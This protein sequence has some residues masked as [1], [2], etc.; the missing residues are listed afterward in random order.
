MKAITEEILRYELRNS[1]PEVYIIPKGKILTPAAREYLQQRKIRFEK[2]G[3]DTGRYQMKTP[4]KKEEAP[5]ADK[6]RVV[7]TEVPP[8]KKVEVPGQENGQP[9]PKYVD[10]ETGAFYYDKPEHMTQLSGNM[11][12]CKDHPRILFRGKLDSLQASVVLAQAM[13]KAGGGSQALLEDLG[14]I[15]KDLREMMRCDVLDEKM[16]TETIIGLTHKEL[17]EHSHN[18]MKYYSIKQMILP[19]YTMG[20]EY[21]ILNKLRTAVRETEV[22]ACTAFHVDKKY[23][24]ND[25]IEELNRLSSALHIMMCKYLAG[26]YGA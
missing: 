3:G 24:R 14:D 2:E 11:L 19:D 4:V 23:I 21:A 5:S 8:P 1:Q 7:A 26:Q 6:P 15:L 20:T 22:A 18:P 9:R 17:R 16:R 12:V 13:I 10:Y 25:I